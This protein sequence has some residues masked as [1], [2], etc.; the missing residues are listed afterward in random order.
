MVT[1]RG[2]ITLLL[3]GALVSIILFGVANWR[4]AVQPS[5][6]PAAQARPVRAQ[7][8]RSA[9]PAQP[10]SFGATQTRRV[11]SEP[12]YRDEAPPATADGR[13]LGSYADSLGTGVVSARRLT[14]AG[15][16]SAPAPT[17]RPEAAPSRSVP[18]RSAATP[19]G[20]AWDTPAIVEITGVMQDEQLLQREEFLANLVRELKI[21]VWWNVPGTQIQRL[22]LYTPNGSLYRQ[23]TAQFDGD[24]GRAQGS[25][26]AVETQLPVGGTWI[27][28]YSLF[29]AWRVDVYLS[30]Q[31]TPVTSASFILNG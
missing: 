11:A 30:G 19:G 14:I 5:P 16:P 28:E 13:P 23:F 31:R 21:T 22:E 26:T 7:L 29:G 8:G 25:R 20:A 12:S 18:I 24:A 4:E 17:R 3:L 15:E 9:H 2:L 1:P 27:T 10:W 6:A